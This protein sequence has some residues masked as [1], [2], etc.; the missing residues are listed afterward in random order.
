MA[1]NL[2]VPQMMSVALDEGW[3]VVVLSH[4][5]RFLIRIWDRDRA[6]SVDGIHKTF[7]PALREALTRAFAAQARQEQEQEQDQERDQDRGQGRDQERE[8]PGAM[9][10]PSPALLATVLQTV[11]EAVA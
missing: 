11:T 3:A 1:K 4:G 9:A 2:S 7:G 6:R 10:L 5:P 8:R